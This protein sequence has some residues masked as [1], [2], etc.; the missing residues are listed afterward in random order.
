MVADFKILDFF[1]VANSIITDEKQ[2]KRE[3]FLRTAIGRVYYTAYLI[4]RDKAKLKGFREVNFLGVGGNHEKL[5]VH[6][7]TNINPDGQSNKTEFMIARNLKKLKDLRVKSDYFPDEETKKE[8]FTLAIS[9]LNS[10]KLE[11]QDT[12]WSFD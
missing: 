7:E 4:I 11:A 5:I 1:H 8:D 12:H 10:I 3:A 9:L 2:E 6:L